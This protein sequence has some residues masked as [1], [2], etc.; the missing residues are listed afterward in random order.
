MPHLLTHARHGLAGLVAIVAAACT[1]PPEETPQQQVEE[2][3]VGTWLREYDEDATRVRRVLVLESD[4]SFREMAVVR[5]AGAPVAEHEHAGEWRY[6]GTN[7][8]R[9]YNRVDGQ[10][11]SAPI[12]P[13]A[14]FELKFQ[15]PDEFLGIDHVHRR[16]VR[17]RR[18]GDGT[19][20]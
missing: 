7:L 10:K 2:R 5:D 4:R 8:K 20:P 17:Y 13:F 15:S 6:D 11:P 3:L 9:R 1:H 19:L 16:Q 14:T 12:V 18:V